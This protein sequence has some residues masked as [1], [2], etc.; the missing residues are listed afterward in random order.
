MGKNAGVLADKNDQNA[1]FLLVIFCINYIKNS[2]QK[3]SL[4]AGTECKSE[5]RELS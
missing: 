1:E 2:D 4:L 5:N 3:L